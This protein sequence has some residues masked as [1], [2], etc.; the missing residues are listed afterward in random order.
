MALRYWVGGSATWDATAGTKWA[1]TSGG[2]GGQTV[3]TSS[4]AV[5]FDANSGNVSVTISSS[6]AAGSIDFTGFVGAFTNSGGIVLSGNLTLGSGMTWA[7]TL[8]INIGNVTSVI[9]T[10]GVTLTSSLHYIGGGTHSFV[11][12]IV[13]TNKITID[14]T[15]TLNA[16]TSNVTCTQLRM[17]DTSTPAQNVNMGTGTWTISGGGASTAFSSSFDGGTLTPPPLI[18]FTDTSNS[19]ISCLFGGFTYQ[20]IWFSRS[21]STGSISLSGNATFANFKDTGTSAHNLLFTTGTTTTVSTFTV[22]GSLGNIITLSPTTGTST[23]TLSCPSGVISSDYLNIQHC[24][25]AG[26]ALWYAGANSINNQATITSGSGWIF[27]TPQTWVPR[28]KSSTSGW[29]PVAKPANPTWTSPNKPTTNTLATA[30]L[31]EGFGAFTYSGGQIL[32][33]TTGS[34]WTPK[35]KS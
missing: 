23:F 24:V 26:G 12:D 2:V 30:G 21:S 1:L 20:N 9:T 15:V 14:N 25:A 13:M 3:P 5:L 11:G 31:Y 29:V 34:T 17:G 22:S 18:K 19:S 27:T 7:G 10:N 16:G 32:S 28:S 8:N 35:P 4:D 33:S 6:Q